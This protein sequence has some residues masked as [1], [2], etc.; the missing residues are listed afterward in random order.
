M[1][2]QFIRTSCLTFPLD[3][4][5]EQASAAC[6]AI[7]LWEAVKK[8]KAWSGSESSGQLLDPLLPALENS[9]LS[10]HFNLSMTALYWPREKMFDVQGEGKQPHKQGDPK[11]T[12]T[13]ALICRFI[14]LVKGK[15]QGTGTQCP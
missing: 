12:G 11:Q 1:C 5:S 2:P 13:F 3:V 4:R 6:S 10:L 7:Q 8:S 15:V 9:G 14:K